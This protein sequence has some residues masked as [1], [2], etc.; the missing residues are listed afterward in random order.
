MKFSIRKRQQRAADHCGHFVFCAD[1]SHIAL[2]ENVPL[3]D[4]DDTGNVNNNDNIHGSFDDFDGKKKD[5]QQRKK[6][7]TS[8]AR[9]LEH[10]SC[11]NID[12]NSVLNVVS[13]D[14]E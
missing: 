11:E 7:E 13:D 9:L 5:R 14:D 12:Q 6:N 4:N 10:T 2:P 3:S 1:S 8:K